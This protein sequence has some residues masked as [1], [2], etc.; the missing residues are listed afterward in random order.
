MELAEE[1]APWGESAAN[2]RMLHTAAVIRWANGDKESS[3]AAA[4]DAARIAELLMGVGEPSPP[5]PLKSLIRPNRKA[6]T[7]SR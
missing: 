7:G 1:A 3:R 6:R 2:L 4:D 5:R